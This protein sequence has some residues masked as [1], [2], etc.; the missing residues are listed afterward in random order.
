MVPAYLPTH[1][2]LWSLCR[3]YCCS[4]V[5]GVR[6]SAQAVLEANGLFQLAAFARLSQVVVL[7]P[8]LLVLALCGLL[9]TST[10][11]LLFFG[12]IGF[13][14][15]Y[16][17]WL[18]VWD[19]KRSLEA[20]FFRHATVFPAGGSA[21]LCPDLSAVR[22]P[23]A[24]LD[25]AAPR[26]GGIGELRGRGG[27]G[28]VAGTGRLRPGPWCCSRTSAGKRK[29][30]PCDSS[31]RMGRRF[32]LVCLLMGIPAVFAAEP[33]LRLA[34]GQEFQ[35]AAPALRVALLNAMLGGLFLMLINTLRGMNRP[36]TATL[37]G[38]ASC[39]VS[40]VGAV[41]LLPHVGYLG[42]AFGQTLGYTTGLAL[43]WFL[44]REQGL[45]L[46]E[47]VPTRDGLQQGFLA[48]QKGRGLS[49][50]FSVGRA[51]VGGS[52]DGARQ[53]AKLD[54]LP[55]WCARTLRGASGLAATRA[56]EELLHERLV[57]IRPFLP[58]TWAQVG[59]G[60]GGPF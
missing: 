18:M 38:I 13:M 15:L 30:R 22:G 20:R 17:V 57:P 42:A 35:S 3:W 37:I 51:Q 32:V 5:H 23:D 19:D 4:F 49:A 46:L 53:A 25:A 1:P 29:R 27:G 60:A 54:C 48:G 28:G 52:S 2:E 43:L 44:L 16:S 50:R 39:R 55:N 10:Y 56:F 34:F 14:N 45:S 7:L 24:H 40:T 21:R 9:V 36:G 8:V 6:T 33:I 12:L 59:P 47:L 26:S 58:A 11:L 31:L 41:V